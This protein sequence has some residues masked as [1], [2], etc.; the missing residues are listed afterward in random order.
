MTKG[1][2]SMKSEDLSLTRESQFNQ[3]KKV[4]RYKKLLFAIFLLGT[5]LVIAETNFEKIT[6]Y[7]SLSLQWQ[8][9][10]ELKGS[11]SVGI[12]S[13]W[14]SYEKFEGSREIDIPGTIVYESTTLI[15]I[16]NTNNHGM[17]VYIEVGILP[18]SQVW[19]IYACQQQRTT[20]AIIDGLPAIHTTQ[21]H[22]TFDDY[23]IMT[24]TTEYTIFYRLGISA[25]TS[26]EKLIYQHI[27]D[28]FKPD[29]TKPF[30][31]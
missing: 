14:H 15:T 10:H 28:T 11:F 7:F 27:L 6:S 3:M 9:L 17:V 13:T 29:S 18:D 22:D 21:V 20:N 30:G 25:P 26:E 19:H 2:H 5:L 31:C 23:T 12:P 24:T 16:Q 1:R 4:Q 8:T